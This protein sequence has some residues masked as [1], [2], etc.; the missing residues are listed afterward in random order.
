LNN[1]RRLHYPGGALENMRG[2]NLRPHSKTG[3]EGTW[4]LY[5]HKPDFTRGPNGPQACDA[6]LVPRKAQDR[7]HF[8]L[9]NKKLNFKERKGPPQKKRATP[10]R[11]SLEDSVCGIS[12]IADLQIIARSGRGSQNRPLPWLPAI[13]P[14]RERASGRC[15]D[16]NTIAAISEA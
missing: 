6:P 7:N 8:I 5:L 11:T 9:Y 16:A 2:A 15:S 4:L 1:S 3:D 10:H 13:G 12:Q 14:I